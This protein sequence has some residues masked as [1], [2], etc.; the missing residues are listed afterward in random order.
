[1]YFGKNYASATFNV[2]AVAIN[3][4]LIAGP[5]AKTALLHN[6]YFTLALAVYHDQ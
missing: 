6:N 2:A 5:A 4:I 3:T 1:M